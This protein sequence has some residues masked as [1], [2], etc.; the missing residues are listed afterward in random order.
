MDL[1]EQDFKNY[2]AKRKSSLWA[3][4]TPTSDSSVAFAMPE[5]GLGV[6]G[7]CSQWVG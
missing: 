7:L 2:K 5:A 1:A 4:D 3:V 6:I